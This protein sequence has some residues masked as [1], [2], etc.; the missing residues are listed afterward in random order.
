MPDETPDCNCSQADFFEGPPNSCC[1]HHDE[2]GA[3]RFTTTSGYDPEPQDLEAHI[4]K[5][6]QV[7]SRLDRAEATQDKIGNLPVSPEVFQILKEILN[8]GRK[9]AAKQLEELE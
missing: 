7:I 2:G 9:I 3:A 8:K 4:E 5:I 1:L 6:D